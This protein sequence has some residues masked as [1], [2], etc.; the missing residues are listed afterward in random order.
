MFSTL[1]AELQEHCLG[2]LGGWCELAAPTSRKFSAHAAATK[3]KLDIVPLPSPLQRT[4]GTAEFFVNGSQ[5]HIGLIEGTKW[6]VL[7]NSRL[8]T[9]LTEVS[10]TFFLWVCRDF[11]DFGTPETSAPEVVL[12]RRAM[13][14]WN[15]AWSIFKCSI[16]LP[17]DA[18]FSFELELLGT[19]RSREVKIRL[20]GGIIL[21]YTSRGYGGSIA[22]GW[23]WCVWEHGTFKLL[24]DDP[25]TCLVPDGH[26]GHKI[27][28]LVTETGITL[29]LN[30]QRQFH[31]ATTSPAIPDLSMQCL[32]PTED[33]FNMT[34]PRVILAEGTEVAPSGEVFPE[35]VSLVDYHEV[36]SVDDDD[37]DD[38]QV[39]P[40][41]QYD[42]EDGEQE[43]GEEEDGEEGEQEEEGA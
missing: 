8:P 32:D 40:F 6:A 5:Q 39:E 14:P 21:R 34:N 12:S 18:S 27:T 25:V 29:F 15:N 20:M 28:Q 7:Q 22:D 30:G 31:H 16:V 13:A 3:E 26:N 17:M 2:H 35:S 37:E 33:I 10:E 19:N 38:E 41:W 23:H 9:M 36:S 4:N 43:E 42:E 11:R 24:H 1:P